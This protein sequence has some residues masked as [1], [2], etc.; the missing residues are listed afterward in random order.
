MRGLRCAG[1]VDVRS[2]IAACGNFVKHEVI[3]HQ[4]KFCSCDEFVDVVD[5]AYCTVPRSTCRTSQGSVDLGPVCGKFSNL[6][7]S[8]LSV[9]HHYCI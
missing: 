9:L 3:L 1:S 5:V 8:L 6:I 4:M 7:G 2:I